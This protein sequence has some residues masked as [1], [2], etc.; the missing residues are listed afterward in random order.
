MSKAGNPLISILNGCAPH[1][2]SS[3]NP[4]ILRS[5][6]ERIFA[7]VHYYNYSGSAPLV[8]PRSKDD[9]PCWICAEDLGVCTCLEDVLAASALRVEI[10]N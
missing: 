2:R 4:G 6:A 3:T 9:P 7:L 10:W 8:I 5:S 1:G